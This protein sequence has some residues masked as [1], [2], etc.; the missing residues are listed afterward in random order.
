MM[1]TNLELTNGKITKD[2]IQ[3]LSLGSIRVEG[4]PTY[5]NGKNWGEICTTLS[6]YITK[7][8]FNKYK[9]K[10]VQLHHFCYNNP[11][12][13][14]NKIKEKADFKAYKKAVM[15]F[16]PSMKNI[17]DTQAESLIHGYTKFHE[18]F[19]LD[20]GV[21][22]FDAN[23]VLLPYEFELI[24]LEI[25]QPTKLYKQKRKV[26]KKTKKVPSHTKHQLEVSFF[27]THDF[28]LKHPIYTTILERSLWLK[29][30]SF[31]NEKLYAN[32]IYQIKIEGFIKFQK[33]INYLKLVSDV[34]SAKVKLN[35]K[36]ILTDRKNETKVHIKGGK[37]YKLSIYI[38]TANSYD[39]S[40]LAKN[41]K[42]DVYLTVGLQNL[43]Q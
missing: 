27:N 7:E 21:Y 8:D 5:F 25:Q 18:Y 2:E 10:T 4:K 23:V 12:I 41:L 22:C 16:K 34:Y 17:S 19:D 33:D 43:Y 37:F 14:T 29:N 1:R 40:L 13:P 28:D 42:S 9:K 32:K 6:T 31:L 11:S 20:S 24:K 30:K 36:E 38:K 3:Q 26:K 39:I 35:D 15:S